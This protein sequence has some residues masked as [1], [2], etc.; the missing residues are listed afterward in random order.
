MQKKF[1]NFLSYSTNL[2]IKKKKNVLSISLFFEIRFLLLEL[3]VPAG[4]LYT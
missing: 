4:P 1:C 3:I 2:K